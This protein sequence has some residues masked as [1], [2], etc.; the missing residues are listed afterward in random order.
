[1]WVDQVNQLVPGLRRVAASYRP[2]SLDVGQPS[3]YA[4]RR[5]ARVDPILAQR[6]HM[7]AG[8][9]TERGPQLVLG[10]RMRAALGPGVAEAVQVQVA[11]GPRHRSEACDVRAALVAVEGVE[12]VCV[13]N[14]R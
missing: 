7:P 12:Q 5:E 13:F 1:M 2:Q 4:V 9:D 10:D 8:L 6:C 14:A 11:A 3:R